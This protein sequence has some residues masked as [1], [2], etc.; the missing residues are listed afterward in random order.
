VRPETR[1][2]KGGAGHIAYQ[3]VGEGPVDL[4][5]VPGFI[6]H[7]D[8]QWESVG[9][10]RFV[11]RL[12]SFSR[13]IRHDKR[14]TG[15]SDPVSAVP[16]PEE[17]ADDLADVMDAAG[18]GRAVVFGYSEGGHTAILFA[19]RRPERTAGLLL[20]G[21]LSMPL[22]PPLIDRFREAVARWG[23]GSTLR[24]FS[25]DS[26]PTQLQVD[27]AAAFERAAAS[28]GMAAA[29]VEAGIQADVRDV[30]PHV[31]VPTLVIHRQGD[32]V[33]V[34]QG[35]YL[36][37]HIPGAEYVELGGS[38]HLPWLGDSDTVLTLIEDFA[39]RFGARRAAVRTGS[40]ARASRSAAGW[41]SLTQAE[42][43]V[44]TL[45]AEGLPNRLI[46][47]HLFISRHT[48]ESHLKHAF[49]KLGVASRTELA[50]LAIRVGAENH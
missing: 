23:T 32:L 34:E 40:P 41:E 14:G 50:T 26:E 4:V 10:R 15:L 47:S 8:L 19:A 17:R 33:S 18:S 20:Y 49:S 2:A 36:A 35:R 29:L 16:T 37:D 7:L 24:L 9:Y 27:T 22:P 31:S 42:R 38:D 25:P 44:A 6:S 45:A 48:V 13:V 30:L 39:A 43:R 3:V 46:A 5:L 1:Y 21:T 28:P 12:A 11:R